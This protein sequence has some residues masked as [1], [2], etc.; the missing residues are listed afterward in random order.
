[1]SRRTAPAHPIAKE[2]E[3]ESDFVQTQGHLLFG[4][5]LFMPE[6]TSPQPRTFK[7]RSSIPEGLQVAAFIACVLAMLFVFLMVISMVAAVLMLPAVAAFGGWLFHRGLR[8]LRDALKIANTPTAKVASAA[9]GLVE[10]EG[11]AITERPTPAGASGRPSVWWDVAVDAWHSEGKGKGGEWCHVLSRHG[12]SAEL[13]L[14]DATGRM[15]VWLKDA[16]VLLQEHTWE[17]GKDTLPAHGAALLQ[18]VSMDWTGGRRLRVREKR[19]EANGMLFL[20]GTL[21]EGRKV[22]G[23][24]ELHG[25][26][27]IVHA[28]RT[29]SWRQAL[30]GA[31][32]RLLRGPATVAFAYVDMMCGIGRSGEHAQRLADPPPP[33]LDGGGVLVWKGRAGR[34]FVVSDRRETEALAQ[35]RKRSLWFIAGGVGVL[36]YALHEFIKAF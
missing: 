19:M 8:G 3:P 29:G 30:V 36:C 9:M 14:E 13:V 6:S 7:P 35:L 21:D 24:D 31:L 17:S 34:T 23:A 1:L 25:I 16:D 18:S 10:L 20:V 32:P 11:R 15:P 4:R 27:R 2:L 5:S 12:G 22:T 26:A 28:A 33:A